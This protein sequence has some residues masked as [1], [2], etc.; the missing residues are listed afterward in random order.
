MYTIRIA[1]I[2]LLTLVL[3]ITAAHAGKL[4][5]LT[6]TDPIVGNDAY[7]LALARSILIGFNVD[8]PC[9][10]FDGSPGKTHAD[11]MRCLKTHDDAG[12]LFRNG[13]IRPQCKSTLL[14]QANAATCGYASS[15]TAAPCV[16][17][18][19][20]GKVTCAIKPSA[21]CVDKPGKFSQL[22]CAWLDCVEAADANG[23]GRISAGRQRRVCGAGLRQRG[24]RGLRA[25][26]PARRDLRGRRGVHEVLLL[27]GAH[28]DANADAGSGSIH[29]HPN[30]TA[31][32]Q[33]AD[34]DASPWP[35]HEHIDASPTLRRQRRRHAVV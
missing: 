31:P 28:E 30:A 27:R 20:A 3:S 12:G 29:E 22:T 10:S 15:L 1:I 6:G 4:T 11:W 21:Q 14:K 7:Q 34:A 2:A 19:L 5:C 33:H 24:A 35:T 17:K 8:C 26:R 32:E 18:S 13:Y 25:V 9:G 23:D 16:K